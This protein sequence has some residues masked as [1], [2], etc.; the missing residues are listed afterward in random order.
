MVDEL[1]PRLRALCQRLPLPNFDTLRFLALHFKR[2]TWFELENLMTAANI[3]AVCAPSLL[4]PRDAAAL[5][6]S[7]AAA[8]TTGG[9]PSAAFI[10]DAHQ[11]SRERFLDDVSLDVH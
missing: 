1:V 6:A 4:W 7:H 11:V 9:A 5:A 3:A 10:N 2:V 8:A